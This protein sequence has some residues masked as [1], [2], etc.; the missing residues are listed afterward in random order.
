[1]QPA[2]ESGI[3]QVEASP[4]EMNR[5]AF[6]DEAR[7]EFL[8]HPAG[9]KQNPPEA[10]DI[11][12]VVRAVLLVPLKRNGFRNF[13]GLGVDDATDSQRFERLH[14]PPVKCRHG[15]WFE[16][17]DAAAALAGV[18]FEPVLQEVELDL[19]Y[20]LTTGDRR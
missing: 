10:L 14:Q 7:S 17:Q 15:L 12:G 4:E 16:G 1:R 6:A 5:A 3:S 8:N 2:G 11:L 19:E 13:L 20:T 9:G 18:D